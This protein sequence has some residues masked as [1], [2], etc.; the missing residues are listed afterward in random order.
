MRY[1]IDAEVSH[2]SNNYHFGLTPAAV[3][4]QY[5]R[6]SALKGMEV[7]IN[8]RRS[9]LLNKYWMATRME[10]DDHFG[11]S[12]ASGD[13]DNDGYADLAIGS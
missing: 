9:L 2:S 11:F 12:L 3:A 6:N 13:F 1:R 5:E 4:Q 7:S 10:D 8:N